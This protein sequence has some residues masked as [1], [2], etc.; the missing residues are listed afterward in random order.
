M[1]RRR[2]EK[3]IVAVVA[4]REPQIYTNQVHGP[5][6]QGRYVKALMSDVQVELTWCF[7]LKQSR[8]G[9]GKAKRFAVRNYKPNISLQL[10]STV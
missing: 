2:V 9:H 7:V 3:M 5:A 8:L 10:C 1:R 4:D 6:L